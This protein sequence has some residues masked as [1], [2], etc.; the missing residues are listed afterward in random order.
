MT[1]S[2]AAGRA[3][4][5]RAASADAMPSMR[6]LC[7]IPLP[8]RPRHNGATP[9]GSTPAR[10]AT[11]HRVSRATHHPVRTGSAVGTGFTLA[12]THNEAGETP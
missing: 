6:P 7:C 8:F 11:H 3:T 5:G 10:R 2:R 1:I 12:A 4:G 9:T